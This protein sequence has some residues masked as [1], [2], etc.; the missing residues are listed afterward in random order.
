MSRDSQLLIPSKFDRWIVRDSMSLTFD[1]KIPESIF[2]DALRV[3]LHAHAR[4]QFYLGDAINFGAQ[5]WQHGRY[6][7]FLRESGY[8]YPRLR[9]FAWVARSVPPERRRPELSYGFHE[10]VARLT[11]EQQTR[12]LAKAVENHW[13]VK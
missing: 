12:S 6:T 11:P 1:P 4:I 10:E 5:R 13:P 9:V 7:H 8:S 2:L 3:L